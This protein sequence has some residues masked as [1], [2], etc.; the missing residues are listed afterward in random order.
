ML[1]VKTG[2]SDTTCKHLGSL[3]SF[4][5]A[6]S[7]H[8]ISSHGGGVYRTFPSVKGERV[9][10]IGCGMGLPSTYLAKNGADVVVAVDIDPRAVANTLENAQRNNIDNILVLQSDMFSA[11]EASQRFDAIFWTFPCT[12]VPEDYEFA[13]ENGDSSIRDIKSSGAF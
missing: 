11:V 13:S 12:H 5:R 10:E 9:L 3:S 4:M 7:R 2:P 8:L 6:Y 1:K